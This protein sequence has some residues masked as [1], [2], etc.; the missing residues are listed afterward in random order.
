MLL[1]GRRNLIL[2]EIVK[3]V[4]SRVGWVVRLGR[5]GEGQN[6]GENGLGS[7]FAFCIVNQQ[8]TTDST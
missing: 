6:V 2:G 1:L 3:D 4:H 5:A 8:R 7:K